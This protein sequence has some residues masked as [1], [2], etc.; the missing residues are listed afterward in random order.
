MSDF[1]M[2]LVKKTE[3]ERWFRGYGT[4]QY[5]YYAR[6]GPKRFLGGAWEVESYEEL[7]KYVLEYLFQPFWVALSMR[8]PDT[9]FCL[10]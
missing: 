5:T 6:E 4:D 10:P 1:G 2:T 7:E 9:N 8:V 3:N